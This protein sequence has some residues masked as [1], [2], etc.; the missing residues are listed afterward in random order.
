MASA[1]QSLMR[2][3]RF[4]VPLCGWWACGPRWLFLEWFDQHECAGVGVSLNDDRIFGVHLAKPK[5]PEG[6]PQL[7]KGTTGSVQVQVMHTDLWPD[8][9]AQ[10]TVPNEPALEPD[11]RVALWQRPG[12]QQHPGSLALVCKSG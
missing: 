8:D 10:R 2:L 6:K 5:V 11:G 3:G 12:G 9:M 1:G 4:I 7:A